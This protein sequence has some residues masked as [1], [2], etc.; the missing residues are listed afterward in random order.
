MISFLLG[1]SSVMTLI[2]SHSLYAQGSLPIYLRIHSYIGSSI[3]CYYSHPFL[4]NLHYKP[5]HISSDPPKCGSS[6]P[7][8]FTAFDILGLTWV[9]PQLLCSRLLFFVG[10]IRL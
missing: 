9:L 7:S 10:A 6:I 8:S 3:H 2:E 5:V 1:I 4:K